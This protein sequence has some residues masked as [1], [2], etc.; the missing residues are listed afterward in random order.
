MES[1][2]RTRL[3]EL[4]MAVRQAL[5]EMTTDELIQLDCH[6]AIRGV[7]REELVFQIV[8]RTVGKRP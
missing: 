5:S 7:S 6:A 3:H 8:S 2:A 1:T 4:D